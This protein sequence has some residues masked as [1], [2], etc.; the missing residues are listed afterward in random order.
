MDAL[1]MPGMLVEDLGPQTIGRGTSAVTYTSAGVVLQANTTYWLTLGEAA[2][3]GD[4]QWDGTTSTAQIPPVS[5]TTGD[6]ALSS[7]DGGATWQQV[8]FGP[9]NESPKFAIDATAAT[10]PEP[11][12]R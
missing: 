7:G 12:S 10:V 2:G 9:A 6:Q 1:G 5:W 4:F 3:S 8:F 11:H